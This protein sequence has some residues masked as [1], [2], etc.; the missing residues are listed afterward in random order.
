MRNNYYMTLGSA[1]DFC[2]TSVTLKLAS[3]DVNM[4]VQLHCAKFSTRRELI[5]VGR[6]YNSPGQPILHTVL[7]KHFQFHKLTPYIDD[8]SGR[9]R[10]MCTRVAFPRA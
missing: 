8:I 6:M 9:F 7:D 2:P 3:D 1:S 5:K 4:L 10:A